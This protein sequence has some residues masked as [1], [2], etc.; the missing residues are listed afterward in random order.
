VNFV[1]DPHKVMP[2][3]MRGEFPFGCS[4]HQDQILVVLVILAK[5]MDLFQLFWNV[6]HCA[7]LFHFLYCNK[8]DSVELI[9]PNYM[10]KATASFQHFAMWLQNKNLTSYTI[11]NQ[12]E[13]WVTKDQC[14]LT[15]I[16]QTQLVFLYNSL[17]N[18][19]Q[20]PILDIPNPTQ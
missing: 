3:G 4:S 9:T 6:F 16:S 14:T 20:P 1:S 19:N 18:R 10:S 13:L 17:E 8:K 7:I 11:F 12:W 5:D 15:S 2:L